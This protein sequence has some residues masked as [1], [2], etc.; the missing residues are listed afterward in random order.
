MTLR[1]RT[2]IQK[3]VCVSMIQLLEIRLV[4][5]IKFSS[6]ITWDD[7]MRKKTSYGLASTRDIANLMVA[8]DLDVQFHPNL[9]GD[10]FLSDIRTY[11]C[12]KL[13]L[14]SP[15]G[16]GG[17]RDLCTVNRG[18][19]ESWVVLALFMCGLCSVQWLSP[20]VCGISRHC[21]S[22]STR[23]LMERPLDGHCRESKC[24]LC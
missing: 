5:L 15:R 7:L 22:T 1:H 11:I 2:S 12:C 13:Y 10:N 18:Q 4:S 9:M 21:F 8:I 6:D 16:G 17:V 19:S 20:G 14:C 23:G 24:G 3:I